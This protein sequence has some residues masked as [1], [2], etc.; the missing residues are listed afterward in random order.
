MGKVE[1][2]QSPEGSRGEGRYIKFLVGCGDQVERW[3]TSLSNSLIKSPTK[4]LSFAS[5]K[6]KKKVGEGGP[7]QVEPGVLAWT[8]RTSSRMRRVR[9]SD[10]VPPAK[11]GWVVLVSFDSFPPG[12]MP[13]REEQKWRPDERCPPFTKRWMDRVSSYPGWGNLLSLRGEFLS[14]GA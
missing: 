4:G 14:R 5:E 6:G 1:Q 11:V 12:K 7:V 13:S 10:Q 3:P 8:L 2:A 9:A